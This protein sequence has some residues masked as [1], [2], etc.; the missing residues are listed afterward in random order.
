MRNHLNEYG[1]FVS[2][3]RFAKRILVAKNVDY[4]G[5]GW[6]YFAANKKAALKDLKDWLEIEEKKDGSKVK[7]KE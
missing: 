7:L 3:G 4:S 5:S 6:H 2:C 1:S